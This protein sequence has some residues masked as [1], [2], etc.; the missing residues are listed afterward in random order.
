M[1]ASFT[2]LLII[3]YWYKSFK[4]PHFSLIAFISLYI[5]EYQISTP[6]LSSG[7]LKSFLIIW[8]FFVFLYR[9][10]FKKPLTIISIVFAFIIFIALFN[11]GELFDHNSS[12]W[13]LTYL[14]LGMLAYLISISFDSKKKY[15]DLANCFIIS[16]L[17]GFIFFYKELEE[18]TGQESMDSANMVARFYLIAI[19]FCFYYVF[20][21]KRNIIKLLYAFCSAILIVGIFFTGSRSILL[22]V[23]IVLIYLSYKFNK[24]SLQNMSIMLGLFVIIIFI[25]PE[26]L[27]DTTL[28]SFDSENYQSGAG[29]TELNSIDNNIRLSLWEA[30]FRMFF[31][32]NILIGLGI[33]GYRDR[34]LDYLPI[35]TYSV[36]NAHN[37]YLAILFEFGIIGFSLF[38]MIIV[39][40]LKIIF[41]NNKILTKQKTSI[42]DFWRVA[43]VVYLVSCITKHDHNEK[44]IYIFI[45][46]AASLEYLMYNLN[47]QKIVDK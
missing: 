29:T 47:R 19:I 34:I 1:S 15:L 33:N 13:V 41:K 37:T 38:I 44:L 5:L 6:I 16:S 42:L 43:F 2:V 23:P 3:Y 31:D 4:E 8:V 26:V 7:I 30:G 14:Q 22:I 11:I 18:I 35:L 25:I 32:N 36:T 10:Q 46:I 17:L 24:L 27:M 20:T 40:S 45:G 39:N 28:E 21:N 12:G 9:N